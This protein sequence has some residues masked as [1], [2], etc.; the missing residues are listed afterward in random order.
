MQWNVVPSGVIPIFFLAPFAI[1]F[2]VYIFFGLIKR[3]WPLHV[4]EWIMT[5][6]WDLNSCRTLIPEDK[7]Q[8]KNN[9]APLSTKRLK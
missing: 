8:E 6:N 7:K 4:A 1:S 9:S 5:G 2:V 3:R